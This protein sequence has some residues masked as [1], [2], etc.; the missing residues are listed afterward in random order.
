MRLT[1]APT[2]AT[3]VS[4]Y[5]ASGVLHQVLDA[6]AL[7]AGARVPSTPDTVP[8]PERFLEGDTV[9][10]KA[11]GGPV[12]VVHVERQPGPDWAS[13]LAARWAPVI[14]QECDRHDW[15]SD[16]IAAFHFDGNL[17]GDDNW[18][19]GAR[20]PGFPLDGDPEKQAAVYWWATES[21]THSFVG[22]AFFHPRDWDH[23]PWLNRPRREHAN[24][25]EGV[26]LVIRKDGEQLELLQTVNHRNVFQYAAD[27]AAWKYRP[28]KKGVREKLEGRLQLQDGHPVVYIEAQGHGVTGANRVHFLRGPR[29]DGAT[30]DGVTYRPGKYPLKPINALWKMSRDPAFHGP[31]RAFHDRERFQGQTHGP[32]HSANPP[33]GWNEEH[34]APAG[35]TGGK[36]ALFHRPGELTA[37]QFESSKP[38]EPTI[39]RRSWEP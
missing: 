25:M 13:A 28:A 36:G 5:N 19:N 26:L 24:D 18:E 11:E 29:Y 35:W 23:L 14:H 30:G 10:L 2:S 17:N 32:P 3:K 22:Y 7:A 37:W 12:Q 27:P 6:G 16:L 31:G 4:V 38:F 8:L 34:H 39:L 15:R 1:L 21:A 33:W 9:F 20:W